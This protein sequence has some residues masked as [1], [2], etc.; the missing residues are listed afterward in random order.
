VR[1]REQGP[2]AQRRA[3]DPC[4]VGP[5]PAGDQIDPPRG[6]ALHRERTMAFC[7]NCGEENDDD[8][9]FCKNC[10]RG[11]SDVADA[12]AAMAPP[13]YA[14]GAQAD[15]QGRMIADD[16]LPVGQDLDGEPGG[17]RLLWTGR[18]NF[19][20]SPIQAIISRYKVTNERLINERGFI[21]KH[22]EQIDLFRVNDVLIRQGLLQRMLGLGDVTVVSSD[23]SS[24]N[25]KL[26]DISNPQR[27]GDIIRQ[28]ARAEE[29]RRRVF[30]QEAV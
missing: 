27:V 26:L 22:T 10:G 18:P 16:G 6:S 11:L 29:Q 25:R 21:T 2:V 1:I 9:K 23:Q 30:R 12:R 4:S 17:E 5:P 14:G 19:L 20:T 7:P 13:P 15:A 8:A 24:P 28:A 3:A